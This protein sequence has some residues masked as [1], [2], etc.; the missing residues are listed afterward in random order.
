MGAGA[1]NGL[2]NGAI[3]AT[4]AVIFN[5]S[6]LFGVVIGSAMIINLVT[7]GFFGAIVPMIMKALK[8][9]PASSATIFITTATDVI[10]FFVFLGLATLLLL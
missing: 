2:I 1:I 3:V 5:K 9:D 6:P 10:G 8:K 4:I 7:A